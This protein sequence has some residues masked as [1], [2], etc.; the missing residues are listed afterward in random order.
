MSEVESK[1]RKLAR[2]DADD[3]V[4]KNGCHGFDNDDGEDFFRLVD[5]FYDKRK[6]EMNVE[7][8]RKIAHDI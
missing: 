5:S 6:R 1:L 3:Y 7:I 4:R 8:M 2:Q